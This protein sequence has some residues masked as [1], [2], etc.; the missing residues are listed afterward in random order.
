[1]GERVL[2]Y[3]KDNHYVVIVDFLKVNKTTSD[4]SFLNLFPCYCYYSIVQFRVSV[5]LIGRQARHGVPSLII[6]QLCYFKFAQHYAG[7]C[8]NRASVVVQFSFYCL[9]GDRETV[10]YSP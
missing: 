1:M 7:L 2:G 10:C 6:N 9:C 3:V 8:Y 4:T 5:T